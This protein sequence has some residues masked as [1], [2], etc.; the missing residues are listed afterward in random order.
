MAAELR[1]EFGVRARRTFDKK[2]HFDVRLDGKTVFSAAECG[3]LPKAGE[4]TE[5]IRELDREE[6]GQPAD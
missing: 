4:V 1:K 2:V 3:H 5:R 6:S